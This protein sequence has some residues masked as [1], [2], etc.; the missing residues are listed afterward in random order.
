LQGTAALVFAQALPADVEF[1][2]S[3]CRSYFRRAEARIRTGPGGR[4]P[5]EEREH[6]G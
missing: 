3:H 4:T 6:H 5:H 2:M 1:G